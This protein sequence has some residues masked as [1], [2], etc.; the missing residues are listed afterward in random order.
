MLLA[1]R[2][3]KTVFIVGVIKRENATDLN[4]V[5]SN[6]Q[7]LCSSKRKNVA[8]LPESDMGLA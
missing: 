6:Y 4:I 7:G 8:F 5:E 3:C 2:W 1:L